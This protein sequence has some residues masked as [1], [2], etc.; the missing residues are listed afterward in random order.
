M[1]RIILTAPYTFEEEDISVPKP[2]EG[3]VLLKIRNFGICGSDIQMYHGL[4]KF[5]TFPVVIGHEVAATV[6]QTGSGVSSYALGDNVTIEPQVY[7]GQCYPC[8]TGRFNVCENIRIMGVHLNGFA[9]EYAVVGVKYLHQCEGLSDD[10][11]ALIEPLAVGIGAVK[12]AGVL[13]GKKVLVMGAGT[14]GNLTA[15]SAKALG[16]EAV[17]VADVKQ[18][19]LDYAVKCGIDFCVNNISRDLKD[20]II[21]NFG[22]DKA[23]IIIDC[24]ATYDALR[25]IL[26]VARP[27]SKIIITGNYKFPVEIDLTILQRQ[28][29]SLIGHM[30]YVRE[31]FLDA[32]NSVKDGRIFL[33]GFATQHY[34]IGDLAEAFKFTDNNPDNY[35]KVMVKID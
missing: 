8:R 32:I 34:A 13:H 33:D 6:V 29:I 19:K 21:E 7:C 22:S 18:K 1:K 20:I 28:E 16:A 4:H 11:T 24:A 23:D 25:S 17:M 35:M 26:A 5:M 27:N 9:S 10:Q 30:M 2:K 31:D 14:I 3:E 15:Q 12:R